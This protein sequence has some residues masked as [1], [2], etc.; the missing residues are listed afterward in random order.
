MRPMER[1]GWHFWIDRGGTFTD[2]VARRPDGT[3]THGKLLSEAPGQYADAALEGIRRLLGVAAEAPLPVE[4]IA[5][6]RMGTTVATNA[7]LERTGRPTALVVTRGFADLLRIGQ[8]ERPDLFALKI[9]RPPPLHAAVVEADERLA[10]DG[11]V[12]TPLDE[13]ALRT[14]LQRLREETGI[15]SVAIAFMHAWQAPQHEQRAGAL[16]RELGFTQVTLSHQVSAQMRL[17]GRAD[18]AL[19]DAYLSPVLRHHVERVA[20]ALA[21]VPLYFMQ[22]SGGLAAADDFHGRDAVLSGPAGGIIGMVASARAAGFERLLGFDMGGTSTDVSHYDGTLERTLE[23]RVAGARL[24]VPMLAIHTVAAGGGSILHLEGGRFRVGPDSAGAHPG[25]ACYRNGGPLTVTDANLLL[26]RLQ[27]AHFPALF[28]PAA[29]QPLDRARVE[30]AFTELADASS[31]LGGPSGAEAVAE[32]FLQVAVENMANAIKHLTVQRGRDS[33]DYTL[34]GFGGA[35]G[36]LVCRVAD[37]LGIE[38]VFLHPLAGVLSAWGIGQ[39]EVSRIAECGV[40]QPLDEAALASAVTLGEQLTEEAAAAVEAQAPGV[41]L[42]TRVALRLRYAGTDTAL[43][44]AWTH[45]EPAVVLAERFHTLH[46]HQYGF[47]EPRR[48]IMLEAVSIEVGGRRGEGPPA[49]P[50]VAR[51]AAPT[52]TD[53]VALWA[54]GRWQSVPVYPREALAEGCQIH[55]PALLIEAT[56]TIVIDPGWAA[57][58]RRGG[59]LVLTRH[60]PRPREA[61]SRQA[62]PV[63]LELFNNRFMAIAEQMGAVLAQTASSVNIKER[64]DFSCALFDRHGGLIANAP[65]IPVHLGSM[66]ASVQ[67]V[68]DAFAGRMRPGEAF[69]LNDPYRGGTHLPDVTVVMPLFLAGNATPDAFVAARGHHADIGGLTP[70][71]MPSTSTR[72]D[73]E[74]VL[75]PPLRLLAD[76]ELLESALL[77]RLQAGPFPARDPQRN[78]ADLRAQV[79]ACERGASELR[80]LCER[81]GTEVVLAYLDHVQDNG[82]RVVREALRR[83]GGGRAVMAL[84]NG[85]EIHVAF[86]VDPQHGTATIDFSGTH[87]QQPDNFNAPRAV[88]VAA[89]LYVLRTLVDEPIPL[90]AGCLRPITLIIPPG[91][92]LD[93]APPA[94]V[95]AGNVESSQLVVDALL[96]ACGRLAASQGTMNNLTF[97]DGQH[98]YYETI[99]GGSGAGDGFDGGDAIQSHMTNSRLTDPEVLEW[100]HPVRVERFAIRHGSGG[101]GRW[102]GGHGVLRELRFL[103]PMTVSLLSGRRRIAPPGLAGGGDG[104]CGVNRLCHADGRDVVLPGVAQVEVTPGDRLLI[105]TPGGGGFGE[106]VC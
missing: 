30:A 66:G 15:D 36:Q 6:V 24:R 84:D 12:V 81:S 70:G 101:D 60:T 10:A 68:C 56:G 46:R 57:E 53:R 45:G 80:R 29:D 73:Q 26:G 76:G 8:Q 95:V 103:A 62:D 82:E 90:N 33:R 31:A 47:A 1:D 61:A 19:A 65:H 86:T 7:L 93:P 43:S 78:L 18:T 85:A 92:L 40:E 63:R 67:A 96:A 21:G 104:L 17:I 23:S 105:E 44:V 75:L 4:R 32:G 94:A 14:A 3:L 100:R 58:V 59:G 64:Y 49:M 102:R 77:A 99:A 27:A 97:G 38:T 71:S 42:A 52:A 39:A 50:R 106:K 69:L 89:V 54:E 55:G 87:A 16:A 88:T 13:A 11:Q 48:T 20:K 28:G 25:P 2:L 9:T 79:A 91:S 74:G 35:A 37:R 98:Q 72:I 22:S 34:C 51:H 5:E 83:L 41:R